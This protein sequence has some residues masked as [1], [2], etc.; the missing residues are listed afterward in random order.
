MM[1]LFPILK[2]ISY[3]KIFRSLESENTFYK[4]RHKDYEVYRAFYPDSSDFLIRYYILDKDDDPEFYPG[5]WG[6]FSFT[7][8]GN[9]LY[10]ISKCLSDYIEAPIIKLNSKQY[11]EKNYGR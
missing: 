8:Y 10:E 2:K 7:G 6:S 3:E 9:D 5:I 1:A 11:F 4:S